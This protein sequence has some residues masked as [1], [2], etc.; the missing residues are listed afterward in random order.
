VSLN[1]SLQ[2]NDTVGVKNQ[3]G[4]AHK[5]KVHGEADTCKMLHMTTCVTH[6]GA[7]KSGMVVTEVKMVSGWIP[8]KISLKQVLKDVKLIKRFEVDAKMIMFYLDDMEPANEVCWN[9][10]VERNAKVD[11]QKPGSVKVYDY[12]DPDCS[13][14]TRKYV[15]PCQ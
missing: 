10:L 11:F 2:D 14:L 9:F 1:W 6:N 15:V 8:L 5:V 7:S 12:Y 4:L 3:F 13:K